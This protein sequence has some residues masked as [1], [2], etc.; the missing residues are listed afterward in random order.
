MAVILDNFSRS[1]LNQDNAENNYNQHAV[2]NG[3]I[4]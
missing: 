1:S 3:M 2:K 4:Y